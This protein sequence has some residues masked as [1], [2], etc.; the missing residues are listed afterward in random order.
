[1]KYVLS[2]F[3]TIAEIIN[4]IGITILIFG[5]LKEFIKY[6]IEEFK[7]GIMVTSLKS[8]QKIRCQLYYYK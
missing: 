7:T 4:I 8:I 5:F 6:L 2:T 3:L 1:M